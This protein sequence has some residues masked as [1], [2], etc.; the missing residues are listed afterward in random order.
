M[1]KIEAKKDLKNENIKAKKKAKKHGTDFALRIVSIIIAVIIWFALSITYYPTITRTITNV[2]VT[3]SLSGTQA[4]EKGLSVLNKEELSEMTVDVE[5]KGMNYEIGG[6]TSADLQAEVDL[7]DVSKEGT[8]DLD[9]EVHSAHA[10]DKVTIVSVSPETVSVKLDKITQKTVPVT[11]EAPFV[12]AEK[13]F[14]LR[15]V[16]VDPSELK[17]EGPQKEI[18]NI[19]KAVVSVSD[20]ARIT[21]KMTI[22]ASDIS[23]YDDDD[24]LIESDSVTFSDVKSFKVDFQVYKK[25]TLNLGVTVENTPTSF[26]KDALPM[27][28]SEEQVSVATPDLDSEDEQTVILGSIDLGA[29]DL[30]NRFSFE[31][32]LG[33][34]EVNLSGEDYI[35]VSFNSDGFT[36][37][38]FNISGDHFVL[39]NK[40]SGKEITFETKKLSSVTVF[41]PEDTISKLTGDDLYCEI[42]LASVKSN[43]TFTKNA[44]VYSPKFNNIWGYGTNEVQFVVSDIRTDESSETEE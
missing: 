33:A 31:I 44:L 23:F 7:S 37:K 42:D 22:E 5:I 35:T 11:C 14:T 20:S 9:I 6:Y 24:N 2:P 15:E 4:D 1:E 43:G 29:I 39:V 12:T 25:K 28:L 38:R 27:E 40:P 36:S 18:G 3:I 41:G 16:K 32:P 34:G 13:G 19:T 30:E 26:S 17:I 8:Y 10:A 21:D